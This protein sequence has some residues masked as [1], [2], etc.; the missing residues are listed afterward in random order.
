MTP[1]SKMFAGVLLMGLTVAGAMAAEKDSKQ[2]PAQGPAL[3]PA[4]GG[5]QMFQPMNVDPSVVRASMQARS[6]YDELNRKIIARQTKLYEDNAQIKAIQDQMRDLQKKI[7]A[8]LAADA[9]LAKL[10][11]K[12]QAITPDV[13]S[14]PM[15][16][17]GPQPTP[18]AQPK[19]SKN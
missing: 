2:G 1:V 8:E 10:K 18:M 11:E 9:E 16:G 13:P 15:K 7:D 19:S 12:L 4:P 6:E 17:F 14:G 5:S 3:Q